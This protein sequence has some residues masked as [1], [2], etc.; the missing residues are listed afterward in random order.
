MLKL[1]QYITSKEAFTKCLDMIGKSDMNSKLRDKTRET[2]KKQ[3]NVF[4]VVKQLRN[5]SMDDKPAFKLTR[6]ESAE[7][8]GA[9]TGIVVN[10]EGNLIANADLAFA[11][12]T[13][14]E[15][16][17]AHIL[18]EGEAEDRICPHTLLRM[19][20]PVPCSLGSGLTFANENARAEAEKTYH[21]YEW[22]V[23]QALKEI[24][25]TEVGRLALRLVTSMAPA[26]LEKVSESGE[27]AL[28]R[29]FSLLEIKPVSNDEAVLSAAVAACLVRALRV[30]GY[31]SG[32]GENLSGSEH[33]AAKALYAA[34]T[35]A[36]RH[37][38]SI[39]IL[40]PSQL[41]KPMDVF[42]RETF[43]A[44]TFAIGIFPA[45]SKLRT[46]AKA[47]QSDDEP[48][49]FVFFHGGKLIS[50]MNK[51][52]RKGQA[53]KLVSAVDPDE[54]KEEVEVINEMITFRC[55]NEKCEVGFPL[56]ENTK[57]K[58]ITCPMGDCAKETNVWLKL[59]RIQEL[60]K[61]RR[62]Q[63][64]KNIEKEDWT[65][66][67]ENLRYLVAEWEKIV[68]RPYKEFANLEKELRFA[69]ILQ[70]LKKESD[71]AAAR[72]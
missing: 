38:M 10:V 51:G 39:T 49:A 59:K 57:E 53:L 43:P 71:W 48:D 29:A 22:K 26:G 16:P 67:V 14:A 63:V 46:C 1:K 13:T 9:S 65:E 54:S 66:V 28:G 60:K 20:A 37:A 69:L 68:C 8:G 19:P 52:A 45:A 11:E 61:L 21:R 35:I 36:L 7:L 24:G 4:T 44:R 5:E 70:F 23:S 30:S 17:V 62:E 18:L 40:D 34:V 72:I 25:L 2:T 12:V 3:M 56:R 6:E 27:S 64:A 32:Q 50:L 42:K 31:C 47:G 15:A 41:A 58:V 55:S 33:A